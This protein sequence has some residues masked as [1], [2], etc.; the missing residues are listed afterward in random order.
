MATDE[1]RVK[2]GF[3][4]VKIVDKDGVHVPLLVVLQ[5][6]KT[7]ENQLKYFGHTPKKEAEN[8]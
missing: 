4:C 2:A 7:L 3:F 5:R 6:I 8:E 1:W